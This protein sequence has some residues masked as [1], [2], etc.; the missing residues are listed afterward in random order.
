MATT[1][2]S[3]LFVD[4]NILVYAAVPA[5]PLA[6]RAR[7]RIEMFYRSGVPVCVTLDDEPVAR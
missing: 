3:P 1:D 7:G 6:G 5:S 2:D 4:A